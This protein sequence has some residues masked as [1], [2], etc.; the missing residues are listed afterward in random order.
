MKL[1][2]K[3]IDPLI[4]DV[5]TKS[6]V[7]EGYFSTWGNGQTDSH[8]DEMMRGAFKKSLQE[9]GPDSR[10]PKI[11]HLWQHDS[12]YPLA[13]FQGEDNVIKE[14]DT[15]LFFRSRV[16]RTSYGR[17]VLQLYQDKVINQ[18]S[19][20]IAIV[21]TE[22]AGDNHQKLLEVKLWEG[23]TVTWG[24]NQDTPTVSVKDEDPQIQAKKFQER[25]ELLTKSLRDGSYT[26]ETFVLLELN[27][28]QIQAHYE[29]LISKI[30]PGDPLDQPGQPSDRKKVTLELK[31]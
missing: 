6:G 15:G 20:G 10:I 2:Y 26:D 28:K 14:D 25:I 3:D 29:A 9:N 18:H 12:R 22:R 8:G 16:S 24:A 5:D 23:S 21:K 19:V 17:D 30:Q 1:I 7:V 11:F 31:I 13:R 4:K 27:L